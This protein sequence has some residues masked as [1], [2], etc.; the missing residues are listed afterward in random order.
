[1][2]VRAHITRNKTD[3]DWRLGLKSRSG[4]VRQASLSSLPRQGQ[5]DERQNGNF[6]GS[7]NHDEALV[8][9][10][11]EL[12]VQNWNTVS[13]IFTDLVVEMVAREQEQPWVNLQGEPYRT[14]AL[15]EHHLMT[16]IGI[17]ALL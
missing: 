9:R 6:D 11:I 3:E 4:T 12:Y 10:A 15:N 13:Y 8:E 17:L 2:L 7:L 5:Q 1:M 16:M 14:L